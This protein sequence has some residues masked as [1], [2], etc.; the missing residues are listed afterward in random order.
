MLGRTGYVC[1][2]E[3]MTPENLTL[4][5]PPSKHV[6]QHDSSNIPGTAGSA[7]RKTQFLLL[8]YTRDLV[9]D[10]GIIVPI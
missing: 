3:L 1:R 10:K 8:N 4:R 7:I 9:Q 5:D 2:N 6:R